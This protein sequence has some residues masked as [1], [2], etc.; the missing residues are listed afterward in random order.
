MGKRINTIISL[1]FKLKQVLLCIMRESLVFMDGGTECAVCGTV[2]GAV[3][4][5][6]QCR[7]RFFFVQPVGSVMRCRGCGKVLVSEQDECMQCRTE[8]VLKHTGVVYPL[9]SYRLWYT[10]VLFRWKIQGEHAL[11]PFFAELI[12]NRLRQFQSDVVLVPVPPRPGKIRWEGWD[13]IDELCSFLKYR[14][15]YTVC[16]LLVR[17]SKTEH[18][19]LDRKQRVNTIGNSYYI[20][21]G[22][23]LN[24]A[25]RVCGGR[26]PEEVCLIDDVIT[27]GATI[28]CCALVLCNAGIHSVNA[29]T[30][31]IVD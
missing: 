22:K 26:L 17:A 30:L 19:K 12:H 10:T 16:R 6:R 14:W 7:D 4:I 28:E 21:K 29:V 23:A 8:P 25:L 2:C 27:T 15:N 31:F 5:C 20:K 1:L 13:Q 3:P 18:K 11:S 24:S 9:F